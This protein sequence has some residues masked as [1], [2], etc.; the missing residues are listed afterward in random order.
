[1]VISAD[2]YY[3]TNP[4]HEMRNDIILDQTL[5][6][7][8]VKYFLFRYTLQFCWLGDTP[9]FIKWNANS[10]WLMMKNVYPF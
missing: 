2:S 7:K 5:L 10:I 4:R 9:S 1:M 6:V 3:C 8:S